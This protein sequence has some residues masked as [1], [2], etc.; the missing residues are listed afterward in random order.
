MMNS[1]EIS[2]LVGPTLT[3]MTIS[4]I[5]NFRIWAT[6]IPP[7]TY[8]NGMISFVAGISILRIHNRWERS[9]PVLI[10]LMGWFGIALG[11][12]RIFFPEAKQAADNAYVYIMIA[13]L[14]LVGFFLTF[15][16]YWPEK[17]K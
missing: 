14:G 12:L 16:G 10:T 2:K 6:N 11:S 3:V 8:L 13:L 17:K 15:K 1:K 9:W 4:E 7:V 5:I